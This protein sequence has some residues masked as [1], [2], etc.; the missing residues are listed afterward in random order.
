MRFVLRII[1]AGLLAIGLAL[2]PAVA[3]SASSGVTVTWVTLYGS[4]TQTYSCSGTQ[5]YSGWDVAYVSNGCGGRVWL[6]GTTSGGG[7]AYC[8]NPGAIAYGAIG[9]YKQFLVSGNPV[10]C[11]ANV[12]LSPGWVDSPILPTAL[13]GTTAICVDGQPYNLY[14]DGQPFPGYWWLFQIVNKCNTRIWIHGNSNGSGN[15]YC[16]SPGATYTWENANGNSWN[17]GNG[18]EQFV[19]SGNQAPCSAG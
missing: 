15:S 16:I 13:V 1:A 5:T 11:D 12:Q 4:H 17:G 2:G 10:A 8:V 7:A 14:Y 18:G 19:V 6:H 3:A 9:G